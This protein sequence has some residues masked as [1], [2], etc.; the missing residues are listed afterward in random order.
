MTDYIACG[1]VFPER[2]ADIVR[3]IADACVTAGCALAGGE[4]A[5]HPG[6][7]AEDEF[8]VA[9]A[10]TGVVEADRVLG[11]D[12]VEVGDVVVAMAS[13]GLHSNGY[14]LVRHVLNQAGWALDRHVGELGR[15][16]GEELLEPTRVYAADCLALMNS[17]DVHALAHITGG[18]IA[19]NV[20]RVL[21]PGA[22]VYLDRGTWSPPPVFGMLGRLGEV[23]EGDLEHTFN[24]G[25]GMVA[26]V[27]P[28]VADDALAVLADRGVPSWIAGTVASGGGTATLT[29]TYAS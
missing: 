8:D 2:I 17:V 12:R 4:T 13:S 23:A 16:V 26:I 24:M 11:P 21:A 27:P 22:A 15:T 25:V 7:L 3:G 1:K 14:S 28:E 5:E 20:R 29:G 10:V 6:L 18:G 9:G 19:A